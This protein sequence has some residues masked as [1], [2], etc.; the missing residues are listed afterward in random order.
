[1]LVGSPSRS[2][3]GRTSSLASDPAHDAGCVADGVPNPLARKGVRKHS[4]L[5][6][7]EDAT[8]YDVL[9]NDILHVQQR[10]AE[11]SGRPW[12]AAGGGYSEPD[13]LKFRSLPS[14]Q[15]K[16]H[17]H[18]RPLPPCERARAL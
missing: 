16:V 10:L 15:L 3:R 9:T 6:D 12:S 1:M 2:L 11:A 7:V 13:L 17:T 8:Y 14:S 4:A 5:C 18:N